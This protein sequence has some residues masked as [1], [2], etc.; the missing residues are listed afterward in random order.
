M[1]TRDRLAGETKQAANPIAKFGCNIYHLSLL[2][3]TIRGYSQIRYFYK[4]IASL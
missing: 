1:Q 2:I 4:P 3:L